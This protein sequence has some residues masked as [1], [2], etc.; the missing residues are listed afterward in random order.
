V[1][2]DGPEEVPEVGMLDPDVGMLEPEVGMPEPEVG[3]DEAPD[4]GTKLKVRGMFWQVAG[5]DC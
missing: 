4:D 1:D 5:K 2:D 3:T